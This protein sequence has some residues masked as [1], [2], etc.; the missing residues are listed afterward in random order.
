MALNMFS[1]SNLQKPGHVTGLQCIGCHVSCLMGV[2]GTLTTL[3]SSSVYGRGGCKGSSSSS[4]ALEGCGNGTSSL[5]SEASSS[6]SSPWGTTSSGSW[7]SSSSIRTNKKRMKRF[8][9]ILTPS[10][11]ISAAVVRVLLQPHHSQGPS[12]GALGAL[13]GSAL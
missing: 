2:W 10:L 4:S 1:V 7:M 3:L 9:L 11:I 12:T 5:E 8:V 6:S 13:Q